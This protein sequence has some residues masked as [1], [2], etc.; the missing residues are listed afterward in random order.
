VA[1]FRT[2]N[3]T[4]QAAI[5][6]AGK[7]L[8][9]RSSLALEEAEIWVIEQESPRS[10]LRYCGVSYRDFGTTKASN[11]LTKEHIS[12]VC[13][14]LGL[15]PSTIFDIETNDIKTKQLLAYR[16]RRLKS[17]Q[18]VTIKKELDVLCIM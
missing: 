4:T 13:K 1:S 5:R 15:L 3:T 17:V 9:Y 11:R 6:I 18:P 12:L 10:I 14:V 16:N 7:P 8:L 2:H